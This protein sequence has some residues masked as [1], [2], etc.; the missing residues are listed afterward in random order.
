MFSQKNVMSFNF[1]QIKKKNVLVIVFSQLPL[2]ETCYMKTK[3]LLENKFY[4][5]EG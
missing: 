5:N 2:M 3:Y 1:F 4:I